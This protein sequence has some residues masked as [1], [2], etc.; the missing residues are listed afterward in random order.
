[1]VRFAWVHSWFLGA[2]IGFGGQI[3]LMYYGVGDLLHDE[4]MGLKKQNPRDNFNEKYM[5]MEQFI[6]Y[7]AWIN[8]QV[9]CKVWM[10]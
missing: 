10:D 9:A 1:M 4:V 2:F 6:K 5:Y 7:E 3:S 8:Q